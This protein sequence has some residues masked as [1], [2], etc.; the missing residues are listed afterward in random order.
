[1]AAP[2]PPASRTDQAKGTPGDP[3]SRMWR[4]PD[5]WA[6]PCA[7]RAPCHLARV[8]ISPSQKMKTQPL[9]VR[10]PFAFMSILALWVLPFC[11]L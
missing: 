7:R 5:L 6:H 11:G 10:L 4:T 8:Q 2:F 3:A 1:M 9:T